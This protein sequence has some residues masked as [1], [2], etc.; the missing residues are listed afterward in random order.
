MRPFLTPSTLVTAAALLLMQALPGHATPRTP[1]DDHEVIERLPARVPGAAARRVGASQR[2]ALRQSA[3]A[4]PNLSLALTLARQAIDQARRSG[5]PR[6]WGQAEAALAPWWAEPQAPGPV[7][8]LRATIRQGQ[9][10]FA[11]ALADLDALLAQPDT[12]TTATAHGPSLR[13]ASYSPAA[14]P[15]MALRAQAE[16]TR[17]SI[18]QV[19]G[20]YTEARAGCERLAGAGYAAL[21][22]GVQ[23]PARACLAELGQLQGRLTARQADATLAALGSIDDPWLALLRAELAQRSGNRQAGALFRHATAGDNPGLY[24]LVAYADWLLEQQRPAEVERLLRGYEAVDGLLLRSAIARHR[25][26][27]QRL[28]GGRATGANAKAMA[29]SAIDVRA[30][31]DA[32]IAQLQARFDAALARGDRSHAREQARFALD[33]LG[34]A[35]QALALA[36][37]NWAWQREPADALLLLRAAAAAG[38]PEAGEPVR[39]WARTQGFVDARWPAA[40]PGA[41][42]APTP[43]SASRGRS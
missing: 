43:A 21:G 15:G 18:H 30:D 32:L 13:R 23:A 1:T 6:D 31:T 37:A 22:V 36:Q 42:A 8:L 11:A 38:Q 29:R 41:S 26:A 10:D 7:R 12:D 5:D 16:L 9:H 27:G 28:A 33:L 20:R 14:S 4:Q 3:Q 40:K 34:D 2:E 25:L 19:Q 39:R 35:P 24:A 17:A